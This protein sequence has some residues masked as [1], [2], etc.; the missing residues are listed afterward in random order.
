MFMMHGVQDVEGMLQAAQDLDVSLRQENA[1]MASGQL[2]QADGM[3][4]RML[5]QMRQ[6]R[7]E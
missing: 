2:Q 7:P 3:L 6:S 4:S 5:S 1:D